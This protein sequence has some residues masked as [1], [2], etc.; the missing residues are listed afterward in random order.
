LLALSWPASNDG[1]VQAGRGAIGLVMEYRDRRVTLPLIDVVRIPILGTQY[2]LIGIEDLGNWINHSVESL[3][4]IHDRLGVLADRGAAPLGS[5]P[6]ATAD[7]PQAFS[8]LRELVARNY[9]ITP[10][11]LAEEGIPE[12]IGCLLIIRPRE[13]FTDYDLYQIDQ[14]LMQGK[15]LAL[16]VDA[17]D[18]A[19]MA[20]Q[21][22]AKPL[23]TGLEALLAHYGV[24]IERAWVLDE[25]C[26]RQEMPAQLGGGERP[27]Y[28]APL[29]KPQHISQDLAFMRNI[30]SLVAVKVSPLELVAERLKD[31]SIRAV[32]LLATSDRS[33]E[34]KTPAN[35][36]PMTMRPPAKSEEMR[37]R[38]I[39]YLLEGSFP[40]YFAGK[41]L[42]VKELSAAKEDQAEAPA[43]APPPTLDTSKI[44]SRGQFIGQGKPGRI[45]VMAS[46]EMLRNVVIDES[47]RGANTVFALNALDYL[48]GREGIAVMRAKEQRF[49]PLTDT[50]AAGKT[51]VKSFAIAGLPLLVALFGVGVWFRRR[52]RKRRIREIFASQ[53]G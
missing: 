36:N 7:D 51:F 32:R 22:I 41:P 47:G 46:S 38:A 37:S 23:D 13:K 19:Q 35:L 11:R 18:E 26:Y 27:I 29:I 30:R 49:N 1:K 33:W 25:N 12:G 4:D 45:L 2:K 52:G 42:P 28:Y 21:P 8:N 20:G 14:F 24:R 53:P 6:G 31:S 40:S 17:F 50:S 43:Q 39:A 5:A 10:V 34:I 48:N 9:S 15:S 3:I 16:F 44:E